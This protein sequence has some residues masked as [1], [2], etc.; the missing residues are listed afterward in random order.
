MRT[1]PILIARRRAR[2]GPAVAKQQMW[3]KAQIITMFGN[4]AIM[5][6]TITPSQGLRWPRVSAVMWEAAI[7]LRRNSCK[8]AAAA[9]LNLWCRSGIFTLQDANHGWMDIWQAAAPHRR[10]DGE[11]D[12]RVVVWMRL[13]R[14]DGWIVGWMDGWMNR[15][16]DG[17]RFGTS[18]A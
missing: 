12:E 4:N 6:S 5:I 7:R 10:T 14:M 1:K 17:W 2:S 18:A 16:M 13:E 3:T 8:S 9:G 15:R 11:M